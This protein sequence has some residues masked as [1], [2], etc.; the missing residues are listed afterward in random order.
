MAFWRGAKAFFESYG[1]TVERALTSN[2]SCYRAEELDRQAAASESS[3]RKLPPPECGGA[4]EGE[5]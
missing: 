2:G 1:I 5:N 4:A 3:N